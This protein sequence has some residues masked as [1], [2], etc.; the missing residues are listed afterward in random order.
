[1][2]CW[3]AVLGSDPEP[4]CARW[5][6]LTGT[7]TVRNVRAGSMQPASDETSMGM[8]IMEDERKSWEMWATQQDRAQATLKATVSS[9]ILLDIGKHDR[10]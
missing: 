2:C 9:A 10:C 7:A 4:N 8:G 3:N 6:G 1:M 5:T